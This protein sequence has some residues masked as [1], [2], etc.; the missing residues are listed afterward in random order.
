[1]GLSVSKFPFVGFVLAPFLLA[2]FVFCY[3]YDIMKS[4]SPSVPTTVVHPFT[5]HTITHTPEFC[6]PHARAFII[7]FLA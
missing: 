4:A 3:T 7:A 2:F 1:M 5:E 6:L